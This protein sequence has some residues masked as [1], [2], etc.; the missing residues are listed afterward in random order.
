MPSHP[1][2]RQIRIS[3]LSAPWGPRVTIKAQLCFVTQP[4]Q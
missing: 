3:R 1:G 2:K 4:H